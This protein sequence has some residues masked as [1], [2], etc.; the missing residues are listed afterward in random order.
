MAAGNGAA[1]TGKA[2]IEYLEHT[3]TWAADI[4][5]PDA[6]ERNRKKQFPNFKV[7]TC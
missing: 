3:E 5:F 4:K 7:A 6:P 1:R 2:G